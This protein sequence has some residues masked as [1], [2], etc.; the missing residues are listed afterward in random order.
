MLS[1]A[2]SF[3]SA[4]VSARPAA[5]ET[6]VGIERARGCFAP[7]VVIFTIRPPP[8]WRMCGITSRTSR[9]AAK[10]LR[11]R[12]CCHSASVTDSNSPVSDV[13]ALFTRMSIR[14]KLRSAAA[15]TF[16]QSV[17]FATS[18]GSADLLRH[19]VEAL[20]PARRDHHP[21]ALPREAQR[22]RAADALG[23]AGDDGDL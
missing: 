16:S 9:I 15:T 22:G 18:A 8:C 1:F 10:S 17:G 14:P 21:R 11:S 23:A 3:D 2:Y 19:R 12:S 13:P 4:F 5:R 6:V 7:I 20:L